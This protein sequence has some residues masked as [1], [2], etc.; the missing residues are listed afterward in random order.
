[1]KQKLWAM[2]FILA[3]LKSKSDLFHG[4]RDGDGTLGSQEENPLN[5]T[6]SIKFT[7]KHHPP[8]WVS[9]NSFPHDTERTPLLPN[10][11]LFG[12]WEVKQEGEGANKGCLLQ[13]PVGKWLCLSGA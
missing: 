6:S 5:F 10:N 13:P 9:R 1:M 12:E 2:A 4:E 3:L 7:T 11:R 8:T